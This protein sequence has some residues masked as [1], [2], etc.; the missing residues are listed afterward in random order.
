MTGG[1]NA[2]RATAAVK[3]AG[4]RGW[5]RH[6]GRAHGGVGNGGGV[7]RK[8][9]GVSHSFP[10]V[11]LPLHLKRSVASFLVRF[12]GFESGVSPVEAG[13]CV[14]VCAPAEAAEARP[15]P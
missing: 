2:A 13:V 7:H 1:E 5:Q 10:A 4:P 12:A 8:V 9:S 6:R 11:S 14:S 15:R 3:A